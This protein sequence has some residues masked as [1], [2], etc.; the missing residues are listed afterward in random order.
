[1]T[2]SPDQRLGKDLTKFCCLG[3]SIHAEANSV[4]PQ[5][6]NPKDQV[7]LFFHF[8]TAFKAGLLLN[9]WLFPM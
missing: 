6:V 2:L 7:F 8:T 9:D 3:I 1:M 5:T 4:S